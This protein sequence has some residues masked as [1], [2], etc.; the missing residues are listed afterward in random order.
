[1]SATHLKNMGLVEKRTGNLK[2][3]QRTGYEKS[4]PEDGVWFSLINMKTKLKLIW[5]KESESSEKSVCA[6]QDWN[7]CGMAV[8]LELSGDAVLITSFSTYNCIVTGV[9]L[10]MCYQWTH[11][12]TKYKYKWIITKQERLQFSLNHGEG[13]FLVFK[14][15]CH[16][17]WWY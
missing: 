1:M 13:G 5:L 4:N 8:T 10:K 2:D 14:Q 7:Q 11:I 6:G 9:F 3:Q 12:V 16:S 17:L 15:W